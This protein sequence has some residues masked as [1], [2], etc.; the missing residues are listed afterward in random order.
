MNWNNVWKRQLVILCFFTAI[1]LSI[2]M[3]THYNVDR[4]ITNCCYLAMTTHT[5]TGY[6]DIA[7]QTDFAKW[8]TVAH[9]TAVWTVVLRA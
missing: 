3:K 1:Y 2:D 5:T 7:P 8:L 4:S 6:G 9:M